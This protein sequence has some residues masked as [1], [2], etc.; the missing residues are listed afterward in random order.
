M[1]NS[2][3]LYSAFFLIQILHVKKESLLWKFQRP[4]ESRAHFILGTM[5][6]KSEEAYTPV[7]MAKHLMEQCQN[8]A[9]E[10]DLDD[11]LLDQIGDVFINEDEKVLLDFIGEKKFRKYKK[12]IQKSFGI[13]LDDIAHYKPLVISN[14][15]SESI[16][17]KSFDLAL[18]H[19]LWQ[20]A[21][22]LGMKMN[23]LESASDQFAIMKAIPL[24]IQLKALQSC[25][26]NVS[27]FRKSVLQLS[28]LYK[29]GELNKLYKKSKKSM[30]S[31]RKLMIYDRNEFMA[32]KLLELANDGATFCAVGAAHLPGN[33]GM[34]KLLKSDGYN[35]TPITT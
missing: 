3:L 4:N 24:D 11:S 27:K 23:G 33:K 26:K 20:Y 7:S 6:V 8:Y 17:T 34:L 28:E 16:L 5:H 35:V 21:H 12:V 32:K 15:I 14:M 30:G 2:V 22:A 31:L 18:D 10:M 29:K 19:F 9:G 1:L 25:T 13:D